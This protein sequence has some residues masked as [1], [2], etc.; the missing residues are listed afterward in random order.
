[1]ERPQ[2]SESSR[3]PAEDDVSW[4]ETVFRPRT[5]AVVERAP[6]GTVHLHWRDDAIWTQHTIILTLGQLRALTAEAL[7]ISMVSGPALT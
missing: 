6:D 4:N 2:S 3:I 5:A 7:D 1:M